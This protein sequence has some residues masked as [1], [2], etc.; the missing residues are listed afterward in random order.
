[1]KKEQLYFYCLVIMVAT[2]AISCGG[3]EKK[4]PPALPDTL[5]QI[6]EP[7]TL[8]SAAVR[9]PA[10]SA[11]RV[12]VDSITRTDS[13]FLMK[14]RLTSDTIR[15]IPAREKGEME[16]VRRYMQRKRGG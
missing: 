2:T 16:N 11:L 13:A 12:P 1:M 3:S 9:L 6:T 10:D 8:D 14:N 7:E 15:K 5:I 4:A